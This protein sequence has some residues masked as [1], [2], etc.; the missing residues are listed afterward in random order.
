MH[1]YIWLVGCGGMVGVV[2]RY[3][4]LALFAGG[5]LWCINIVGSFCLG[6]I[7]A[8]LLKRKNSDAW[9]L[10][11]TTGVLGSFTT[12]SSFS[13]E[14]LQLMERHLLYGFS[15]SIGMTLCCFL[16][17]WCGDKVGESL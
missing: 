1:K 11:L 2:L 6:V 16:A 8:W 13:A 14:W 17:V 7:N 12:F 3:A 4:C 15:Y 5:A 9:R 10:F